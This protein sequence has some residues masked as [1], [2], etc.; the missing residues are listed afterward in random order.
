M[1]NALA[2]SALVGLANG[3]RLYNEKNFQGLTM[4]LFVVVA[5]AVIGVFNLFGLKGIE[6]GILAGLASSGFYRGVQVL[7]GN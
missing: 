4:F 7:R 3:V 2:I 6:S 1:D 5:G